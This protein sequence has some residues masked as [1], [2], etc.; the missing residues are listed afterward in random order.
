MLNASNTRSR[1]GGNVVNITQN[2]FFTTDVKNSVRAEIINAAPALANAASE[3]VFNQI[4]RQ[5]R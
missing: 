5:A 1:L 3:Q 2:N 4:N